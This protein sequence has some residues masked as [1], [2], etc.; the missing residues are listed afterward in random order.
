MFFN[1]NVEEFEILF[2]KFLAWKDSQKSQIDRY[3]Y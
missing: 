1:E 3:E 2:T